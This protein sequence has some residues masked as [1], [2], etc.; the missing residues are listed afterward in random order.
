MFLFICNNS[1]RNTNAGWL[2]L[3]KRIFKNKKK[4]PRAS[5][6]EL[7]VSQ[8]RTFGILQFIKQQMLATTCFEFKIFIYSLG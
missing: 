3:H 8:H 6:C 4:F 5:K 7:N 1:D 2:W